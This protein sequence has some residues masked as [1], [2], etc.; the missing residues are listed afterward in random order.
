MIVGRRYGALLTRDNVRACRRGL[1]AGRLGAKRP[2]FAAKRTLASVAQE[3]NN[4]LL[5]LSKSAASAHARGRRAEGS[6]PELGRA[7]DPD[8]GLETT[9]AAAGLLVVGGATPPSGFAM[10]SVPRTAS[11]SVPPTRRANARSAARA[12][13]A[14][15]LRR[16]WRGSTVPG[17][18]SAGS[19]SCRSP[20]WPWCCTCT[21][22]VRHA[23]RSR[24]G[25]PSCLGGNDDLAA[26]GSPAT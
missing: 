19:R 8:C 14:A 11:G 5:L 10:P 4:H 9:F 13:P 22:G 3:A 2:P 24:A 20:C 25:A 23:P 26:R 15:H 21:S 6:S 17:S 16:V 7:R 18:G 1:C 12:L